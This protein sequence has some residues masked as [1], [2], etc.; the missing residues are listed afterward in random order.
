[1]YQYRSS[2][3]RSTRYTICYSV[4]IFL[5]HYSTVKP[6]CPNF[7]VITSFRDIVL[8]RMQYCKLGL[9]AKNKISIDSPYLTNPLKMAPHPHDLRADKD[10]YPHNSNN[11]CIILRL[12]LINEQL[13]LVL[14]I[15]F[16]SLI[17]A[18]LCIKYVL[19]LLFLFLH[20]L[21]SLK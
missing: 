13:M 8:T 19:I 21:K 16:Y 20:M 15:S 2:L 18:R 5:L 17:F 3:I 9:K 7:R 14:L 12:K 4:C 6:A 10:S 11:Q 1:M